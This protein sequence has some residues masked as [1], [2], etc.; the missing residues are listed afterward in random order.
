MTLKN[1]FWASIKEDN[2]RRIWLWLLSALSYVVFFPTI[3]AMVLSRVRTRE[4][5]LIETMGEALGKQTIYN[6]MVER[7]EQCFGLSM[8]YLWI[9]AAGFAVVSAIQGFSY[10]YSKRKMDFYMGLPVKRSRRFLI[11]WLNGIL[12]YLL[13]YLAGVLL[14]WLVLAGNG[15]MTVSIVKETVLAFALFFLLYMGVYHLAILAVMMTGNV[16]ITCCGIAVFLLYELMVREII[17]LYMQTFFKFFSY[18]T[19]IQRPLLSPFSILGSY[20]EKYDEGMGNAMITACYLILFA[21]AAGLTAYICYMKRP[22]EAAG[23]AMSFKITQPV[24]KIL[25]VVPAA[26][27][28]GYVAGDVAGYNPNYGDGSAG[29]MIFVMA[30]AV[31]VL[32]CLIQV[33][34]EFD[35]KGIF[36]KKHHILISAVAAAAVFVIFRYDVFGYDTYIPSAENVSSVAIVTPYEYSYYGGEGYYYYDD[37]MHSISKYDYMTEN[38]YLT[39]VGAVNKLFKLSMDTVEKYDDLSQLYSSGEDAEW[40]TITVIY[41]MNNK[42]NICRSVMVNVKD[43]EVCELLDRIEGSDEYICSAYVGTTGM[44]DKLLEDERLKINVTY[45]NSIYQQKLSKQEAAELLA[46]YKEDMKGSTFSLFRESI[47]TGSMTVSVEEKNAYYT[48]Y[49]D[50]EVKIYPFLTKCVEYLKEHG[51]YREHF[52]DPEDVERI[53]ITN[54]NYQLQESMRE[55]QGMQITGPEQALDIGRAEAAMEKY[56][57][58]PSEFIRYANYEEE[59]DIREICDKICPDNWLSSS[60]HTAADWE[61][62]YRIT[63]YF[64]PESAMQ[65]NGYIGN[66]LFVAGE[67]PEF[68]IR[69]TAVRNE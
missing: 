22:S 60:W 10:L 69:D 51:Y 28:A 35:L 66:F 25:L 63:I 3:I 13:P 67:T 40:Y 68:V 6:L 64:K 5:Y 26:L 18:H 15:V 36:H 58:E 39:D 62:D 52:V 34:Y 24:I 44:P 20:K 41:R 33:I 47:H 16:N 14:G 45:G 23:K 57:A 4:E 29:F 21:A 43:E 46:L 55:Q 8:P 42:R 50:I 2:K 48:S 11:I 65:D 30:V 49:Y 12:V 17:N 9:V 54:Y 27:L 1:S 32:C 53:Q 31:V 61:S 37:A 7:M 38:M 56:Y 59:T 19:D